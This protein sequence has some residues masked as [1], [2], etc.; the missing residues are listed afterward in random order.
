MRGNGAAGNCQGQVPG[1]GHGG[2]EGADQVVG[3]VSPPELGK[4]GD[5]VMADGS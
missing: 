4:G 5:E 2:G 3:V 1:Q